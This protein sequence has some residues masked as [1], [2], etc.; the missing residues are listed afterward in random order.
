MS[1]AGLSPIGHQWRGP[2]FDGRAA[3]DAKPP[4]HWS[5]TENVAW[6]IPIPGA[7]SGTPVIAGNDLFVSTAVDSGKKPDGSRGAAGSGEGAPETVHQFIVMCVDRKAGTVKWKKTV[8]ELVP[9]SGHHRDHFYASASP[10]TDGERVW[11]H[12]GS[13]GTFCL[14]VDGELLWSRADLGLMDTRGGF[15]DGSSPA[16]SGNY[17]VIPWD[18]ER[19]SYITALDASTGKTIWKTER[20]DEPTSWATPLIVE[21]QGRRMVIQNGHGYARGYDLKTGK[22]IWRADGQTTRPVPTPV[23]HQGVVILASG[24]QGSFM[25]AYRLEGARGEITGTDCELWTLERSTPDVPSPALSE[26][27]LYFHAG[28]DG[29][30]SCVDALSGKPHYFRQRV[31]GLRQVY[32]SPVVAGGTSI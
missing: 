23:Y 10:I 12:F 32:A 21:H 11:A 18:Q 8:A 24:H 4:L 30:L 29:I 26:G 17:L 6:K 22:E 13:R 9:H 27:R 19:G 16:L 28:R 7:G 25:G 20:P 2:T 5:G 15:G 3:S 31:S 14:S 1:P